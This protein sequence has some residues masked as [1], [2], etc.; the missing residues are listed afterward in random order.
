MTNLRSMLLGI[1]TLLVLAGQLYVFWRQS[2]IMKSQGKSADQQTRLMEAQANILRSQQELTQLQV[3]WRRYEALGTFYRI[4]FD[5]V[6]E[7]KKA[8][9]QPAAGMPVDFVH[10]RVRC[11]AK[12][13]DYSLPSGMMW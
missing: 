10:T 12:Q 13:D 1:L 3:E 4:A 5:L 7:F 2:Q 8:N 11:F 9:V 6:E